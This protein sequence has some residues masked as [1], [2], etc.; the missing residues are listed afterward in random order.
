MKQAASNARDSQAAEPFQ[1]GDFV[2]VTGASKPEPVVDFSESN[3]DR[4][5]EVCI[6]AFVWLPRLV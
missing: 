6:P 3:L 1:A 4:L 5:I 2:F